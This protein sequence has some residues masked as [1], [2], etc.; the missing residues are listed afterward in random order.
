[1]K[2]NFRLRD[3]NDLWKKQAYPMAEDWITLHAEVKK[4]R[5]LMREAIENC[6]TCRGENEPDRR[7]ARC[8]TFAKAV[9]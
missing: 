6:P 7:C 5:A 4:L 1:M 9:K 2:L 8:Q 3:A